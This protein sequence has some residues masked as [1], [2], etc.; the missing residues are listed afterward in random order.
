VPYSPLGRCFLTGSIK[1]RDDL[2]EG[3]R[4][5]SNPRFTEEK[6][7]HNLVLVDKINQLAEAKKCSPAQLALAWISHQGEDYV[8]IPG[9]SSVER[10]IENAGAAA[11]VLSQ[12]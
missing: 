1:N 5:L 7:Q 11:I 2:E 12:I 3:D 8:L 4:R 6:F 10:L 9:S